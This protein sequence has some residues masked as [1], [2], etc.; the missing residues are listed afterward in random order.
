MISTSEKIRE[1]V[2]QKQVKVIIQRLPEVRWRETGVVP[3][4]C[5]PPV[6]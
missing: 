2:L 5:V 3:L 6:Y 4:F 1:S